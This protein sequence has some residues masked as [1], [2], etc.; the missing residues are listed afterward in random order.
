LTDN[1]SRQVGVISRNTE[2]L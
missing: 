1:L 2:E